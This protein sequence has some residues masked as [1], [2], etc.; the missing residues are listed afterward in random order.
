MGT[1][2]WILKDKKL[3]TNTKN[4]RLNVQS[5]G[6]SLKITILKKITK[7]I[8]KKTYVIYFKNRDFFCKAIVGY[9]YTHGRFMLMYGKTNTVL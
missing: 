1:E 3:I 7:I 6:Q 8:K 4:Q 5:R 2:D 9:K